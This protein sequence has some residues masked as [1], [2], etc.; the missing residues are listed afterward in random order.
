MASPS[1]IPKFHSTINNLDPSDDH[2]LNKEAL[3]LA[4]NKMLEWDNQIMDII[5][6]NLPKDEFLKAIKHDFIKSKQKQKQKMEDYEDKPSDFTCKSKKELTPNGKEF[7]NF[8]VSMELETL[9]KEK[10]QLASE[11]TTDSLSR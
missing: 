4:E 3:K 11:Q 1:R 10:I 2:D 9:Q 5:Q 8:L 7:L 6:L